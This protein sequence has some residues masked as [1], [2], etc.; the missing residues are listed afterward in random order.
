MTNGYYNII[1]SQWFRFFVL[2]AFVSS[3]P[4]YSL[5]H[6]FHSHEES[7]IELTSLPIEIDL[8]HSLNHH[9]HNTLPQSD[10]HQHTYDKHINWHVIRTP[11]QNILNIDDQYTCFS[12]S[13]IVSDDNNSSN[14]NLE[15]FPFLDECGA[16]PSIIR[17]PPLLG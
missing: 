15:E 6:S 3:I 13:F 16:L 17:G 8:E 14:C 12:T 10:D 4:V 2:L 9:H 5:Y 7:S 11:F 1:T